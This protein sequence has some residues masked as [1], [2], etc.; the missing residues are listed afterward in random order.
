M[1]SQSDDPE[2]DLEKTKWESPV[3]HLL[4]FPAYFFAKKKKKNRK[5][6]GKGRYEKKKKERKKTGEERGQKEK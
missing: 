3:I 2:K 5:K 1:A 6:K 4:G